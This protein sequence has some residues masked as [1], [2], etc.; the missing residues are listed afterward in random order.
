MMVLIVILGPDG[1]RLRKVLCPR[2]DIAA[3]LAP[4]E[5]YEVVDP[6]VDGFGIV[7]PE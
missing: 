3:Q 7:E 4:G 5:T 1:A 2:E 6:L